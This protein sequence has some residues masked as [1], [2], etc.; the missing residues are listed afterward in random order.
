MTWRSVEVP[1]RALL[2]ALTLPAVLAACGTRP[3][4]YGPADLDTS[5][6]AA[7]RCDPQVY[8]PLARLSGDQG[9]ATVSATVGSDGRVH[10][11]AL[12]GSSGSPQ[13]DGASL[14]AAKTCRFAPEALRGAADGKTVVITLVWDLLPGMGRGDIG[15]FVAGV[16]PSLQR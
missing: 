1:K 16:Q 2:F 3:I 13:L 14:R 8:P 11:V 6:P 10:G 9:T 7:P 5:S 15:H 4:H 12:N